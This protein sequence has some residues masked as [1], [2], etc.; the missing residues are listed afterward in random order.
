[1]VSCT[2]S[3]VGQDKPSASVWDGVYTGQQAARGEAAYREACMSCH[4]EKLEGRGQTPPLVGS[5]FTS[6]WNGMSVGDLFEKIQVSMPADRPGQLTKDQNAGISGRGQ[7]TARQRGRIAQRSIRTARDGEVVLTA[8]RPI[9]GNS[10]CGRRATEGGQWS[11]DDLTR[12]KWV[13]KQ[14]ASCGRGLRRIRRRRGV[15]K[16]LNACLPFEKRS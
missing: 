11:L 4:G 14:R 3:L 2:A 9:S 10:F 6:N 5:D 15:T 1:M 13:T 7:G 8:R 12:L 16:L